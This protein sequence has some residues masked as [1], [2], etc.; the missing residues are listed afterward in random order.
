M[1]NWNDIAKLIYTSSSNNAN[2]LYLISWIFI[3]N[4]VLLNLLQAILLEGFDIDE[5]K[6]QG[7]EQPPALTDLSD[8]LSLDHSALTHRTSK[9]SRQLRTLRTGSR[10]PL[11]QTVEAPSYSFGLFSPRNK[12]RLL[13]RFLVKSRYF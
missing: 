12:F 1:E 10:H 9:L 3:G 13:C 6:R 4:W 7:V 11:D 2:V 5:M 8:T